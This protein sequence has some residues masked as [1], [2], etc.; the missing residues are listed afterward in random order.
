MSG[1]SDSSG[2]RRIA[3]CTSPEKRFP[4]REFQP[5]PA[6]HQNAR[7][8]LRRSVAV[9]SS[10]RQPHHP[11]DSHRNR[12]DKFGTREAFPSSARL[13]TRVLPYLATQCMKARSFRSVYVIRPQ[14]GKTTLV[15]SGYERPVSSAH[16]AA[17][18][19]I[20]SKEALH[21]SRPI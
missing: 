3:D 4:L 13:A 19:V 11:D 8:T 7:C 10:T 17:N 5:A 14:D 1:L 12:E 9:L 2:S 16:N 20:L 15:D 21:G 6:L 18:I